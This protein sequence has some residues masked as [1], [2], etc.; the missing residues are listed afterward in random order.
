MAPAA[1]AAV[2]VVLLLYTLSAFRALPRLL[3]ESRQCRMSFMKPVFISH[4]D[5]LKKVA[6]HDAPPLHR[7]KLYQYRESGLP[8]HSGTFGKNGAAVPVLFVPGNAGS[9]G[10]VRSLASSA[11]TQY[12]E[13][14]EPFPEFQHSRGPIE[15][16]TL[17]LNEGF[18]AFSGRILEDQAWYI[19]EAVRYLRSLY[20]VPGCLLYTSPS[21][22]DS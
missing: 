4:T 22:R 6:S 8:I 3:N 11:A 15:W 1:L 9:Y 13:N 12:W 14:D 5:E 21:P 7:F 17:E 18:S 2:G 16:W 19:N 10:Q 20:A